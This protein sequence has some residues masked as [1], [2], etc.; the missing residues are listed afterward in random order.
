ML[1]GFVF[2]KGNKTKE[3]FFS[4]GV[5]DDCARQLVVKLMSDQRTLFYQLSN[6][7][8]GTRTIIYVCVFTYFL[9][10]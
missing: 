2:L 3:A 7:N 1:C 8:N 6:F 10:I 9:I 5:C 4:G